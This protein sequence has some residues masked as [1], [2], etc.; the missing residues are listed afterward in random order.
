MRA[1]QLTFVVAL[2]ACREKLPA[3][4]PLVASRDLAIVAHI[5]DDQLFMQPELADAVRG[6]TGVTIVYVTASNAGFGLWKARV[7]QNAIRTA[8][9]AV[10]HD[11]SWHCGW[12]DV[13]SHSAE[14]CRLAS[15]ALS[16]VFV[17]YPDGGRHGE[18]RDSLLHL[19]EGSIDGAYTIAKQPVRYGRDGL[20]AAL[21]TIIRATRPRVIRTLEVA[22]THGD[23]HADHMIVGALAVI[24]RARA[25]GDSELYAYRGY[26]VREEPPNHRQASLETSRSLVRYY[27]ACADKCAPC[28]EPCAEVNPNYLGW[29]E[30]RYAIAIARR[31]IGRIAI[32][33]TCLHANGALGE[34]D[35]APIWRFD[36]D[37]L[38]RTESQ[39]LR[40]AA[41]GVSAGSCAGATRFALDEEGHIWI[42]AAPHPRENMAREHLDCLA[43]EHGRATTHLCGGD[44]VPAWD[45]LAPLTTT[46]RKM[47]GLTSSGRDVRLADLTGDGKADLC[48]IERGGVYCAAG[49]GKGGFAHAQRIAEL[50][51]EPTS[52]AIGDLDGD[53]VPEACGRDASGVVCASAATKFA[54]R[55]VLAFTGGDPRS[56]AIVGKKLCRLSSHGMMC[57][58][59]TIAT[60]PQPNAIAWVG[61]LDGDHEPD[62]CVASD[63]GPQ[64][65]GDAD[66]AS[67][68]FSFHAVVEGGGTY[69]TAALGDVD[70]DGRADL[71]S[72]GD[73]RVRCALSHTNAFGPRVTIAIANATALWL[74]DLDGNSTSDACVD[75]GDAVAC[76]AT[77]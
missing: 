36:R 15:A 33:G 76:V 34:C 53:D 39:C 57:G 2:F 13:A 23:D 68:G 74:G 58:A 62:L 38:V 56:L 40:V 59:K 7:R 10:L 6:H 42:A 46:P 77:P 26:P 54:K 8:Y 17:G 31:A 11:R 4:E 25:I 20:I 19:W 55:N 45:V 64:C 27:E 60:W 63:Q 69:D 32:G 73:G 1:A 28:G 12:I 70:G 21:A 75:T 30:R 72:V 41:S 35:D 22:A 61:D 9:S 49:D 51:A 66:A 16:L 14:H 52:L 18:V 50:V 65:G 47:L 5:D 44:A 3:G 37:G 43:S 67:W 24:A 48:A 29:V 71:C